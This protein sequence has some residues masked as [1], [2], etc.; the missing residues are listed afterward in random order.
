MVLPHDEYGLDVLVQLGALRHQ[1]P[2]TVIEIHRERVA[3]GVSIS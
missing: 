2:Q 1:H 3:R